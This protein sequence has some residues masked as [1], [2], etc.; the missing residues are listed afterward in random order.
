MF[1]Y[2]LKRLVQS[3]IVLLF[4]V[5]ATFLLMRIAPGSP[6]AA[7]RKIPAKVEAAL[8]KKYNLDGSL[9]DQYTSYLANLLKGNFGDSLKYEGRTVLEILAQAF[10][11]SA[12]VG[13]FSL[14]IAL[15]LGIVLGSY[16]AIHH[17]ELLDRLAMLLALLGIC[18]PVFVIAPLLILIFAMQWN[19]LP[20]AGWGNLSHIILPVVCLS[21]PYGAYCAR[22]M[23]TSMLDVLGQD[24]IRTAHAKGL[25]AQVVLYKH[26]LRYAI[27]PLVNYT[28]PLAA[29]LFTGS[30]IIEEI[31]KVPG[32]GSFFV[33][34]VLNRDVFLVGGSVIVY[35]ALLLTL[36]FVV[37]IINV[38]LDRRIQLW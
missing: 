13:G 38:Y 7:E 5:T 2:F 35:C 19:F 24:F 15:L 18:L 34:G 29:H 37:D 28:G 1:V 32:M 25:S 31:F 8:M 10:P 30:M 3:I 20:V 17:N 21:L 27:L 12:L 23:R 9:V 26:A 16:A 36:N 6:F 33:N 14:V 4:V 11:K 22:L